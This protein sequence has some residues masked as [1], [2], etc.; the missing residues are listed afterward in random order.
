MIVDGPELRP[1][2]EAKVGDRLPERAYFLGRWEHDRLLG[3]V[4]VWHLGAGDAEVGWAGERGWLSRGFLR[5]VFAYLW[6]QLNLRRVTGRIHDNNAD[7]I[8][9]SQRLGFVCEGRLRQARPDGGDVLIYGLLREE[10]RV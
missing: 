8:E 10:C 4:A 6:N 7:A 9:A 3:V 1:Y 2:F 5:V